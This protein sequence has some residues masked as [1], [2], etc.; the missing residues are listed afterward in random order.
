MFPVQLDQILADKIFYFDLDEIK[1]QRRDIEVSYE[2]ILQAYMQ[3][4]ELG[5]CG[6][7]VDLTYIP[8]LIANGQYS[9]AVF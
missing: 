2:N 5:A 4:K 7:E 1:S 6:T 8:R 9:D 3:M